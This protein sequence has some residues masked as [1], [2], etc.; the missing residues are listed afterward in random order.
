[1]KRIVLL[2]LT[3]SVM[4]LFSG[5]DPMLEAFFPNA[6]GQ[7]NEG[8]EYE[9]EMTIHVRA[10]IDWEITSDP[11]YYTRPVIFELQQYDPG[12]GQWWPWDGRDF[13]GME[14]IDFTFN[15]LPPGEYR[16][17]V[18]W[19]N[20]QN[21]SL[22]SGEPNTFAWDTM[23]WDENVYIDNPGWYEMEANLYSYSDDASM[24]MP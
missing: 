4:L 7:N 16:V 5:C 23:D 9:G 22:D 17:I 12:D 13:W 11:G 1:M 8:G 18:Y 10:W 24:Y 14:Y 6:T 19:D 15:W 3:I 21:W 20:L 2:I